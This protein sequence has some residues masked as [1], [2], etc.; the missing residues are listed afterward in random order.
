MRDTVTAP[1][2]SGEARGAGGW[3][4]VTQL[5][6]AIALLMLVRWFSR[7]RSSSATLMLSATSLELSLDGVLA[8]IVLALPSFFSV[9]LLLEKE[10]SRLNA[11]S[12]P[13]G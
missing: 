10:F 1:G 8:T 2:L 7:R 6:N 9:P 3:S 5:C 13:T 11:S 12:S 4:T